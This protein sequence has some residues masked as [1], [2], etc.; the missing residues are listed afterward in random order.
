VS[1]IDNATLTQPPLTRRELRA[2]EQAERDA[3]STTT[4]P[5]PF[6]R[7]TQQTM[8]L[9]SDAAAAPSIPDSVLDAAPASDS[10]AESPSLAAQTSAPML[11]IDTIDDVPDVQSVAAPATPIT[12]AEPTRRTQRAAAQDEQSNGPVRKVRGISARKAKNALSKPVASPAWTTPSKPA[13]TTTSGRLSAGNR[14]VSFG[15]LLGIGAMVVGLS[16]PAAAFTVNGPTALTAADVP[17]AAAGQVLP[18]TDLS[19]AAAAIERD[20]YSVSSAAEMRSAGAQAR[21]D[22]SYQIDNTG[23]VRWPFPVAVPL[24]D[25]FG[26]RVSPCGGCSSQHK[27]TDFTP[28]VGT[29]IA[30]IADG[31]VSVKQVSAWGFGNHVFID[32]IVNGQ[33]V[34]SVYAHMLADSSELQVGDVV[35][36]GDYVGQVGSTGAS[37]GPHL[38]FEIRVDG[39][40]QVDPFAWLMANTGS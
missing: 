37:T 4:A 6:V 34:T 33:K 12:P 3:L 22:T 27:G 17:K 31:V 11:S 9:V 14:I 24:S 15:I 25:G 13:P 16:V 18:A 2:R 28:G 40:V 35:K 30:A 38:H 32:H 10:V 26:A 8:T 1:E 29:A 20:A 7:A 5:A 19:E 39:T 36:K 23:T 21:V